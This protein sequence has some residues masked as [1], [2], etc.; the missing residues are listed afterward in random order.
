MSDAAQRAYLAGLNRQ[1]WMYQQCA[2]RGKEG[3]FEHAF[4]GPRD[5][6][7]P[8]VFLKEHA[9]ENVMVDPGAS[10][11]QATEV[12]ALI[13]RDDR[14]RWF[15]SMRSSQALAQMVFGHLRMFRKLGA[16]AGVRA[17]DGGA[18]FFAEFPASLDMQMEYKITHLGELKDHA[19]SIDVFFDG[20]YRIAV[21]CKLSEAE[22]GSCSRP[23]L[24]CE[25]PRYDTNYC[26]GNY[27]Q[28]RSRKERCSLSEARILY[29]KFVPKLFEWPADQDHSP[30]PLN[31]PYQLVRNILAARVCDGDPIDTAMAHALLLYDARNPAFQPGGKGIE[32]YNTAKNALMEP[33][34]LRRCSWQRLI[35]HLREDKDLLW[36][37]QALADKYGLNPEE[38]GRHA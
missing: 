34:A 16:L 18:A 37:T 5:S 12:R 32:A 24:Q 3:L 20:S 19:T 31:K 17:D 1:L 38:E 35:S 4:R 13:D 14:H 8:P 10:P 26:D 21:E 25:D 27:S 36:L 30:C 23:R 2:F 15:R 33:N 11:Q 9:G 6:D 29:W 7:R 22:V 28:Q